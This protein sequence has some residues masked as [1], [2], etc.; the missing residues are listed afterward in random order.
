MGGMMEINHSCICNY[1]R[2]LL[3]KNGTSLQK[4]EDFGIAI[5]MII[6]SKKYF[7]ILYKKWLIL[8]F[9]SLKYAIK[10][11]TIHFCIRKC[12]ENINVSI[13]NLSY[14]RMQ[15]CSVIHIVH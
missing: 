2:Q 4:S 15:L 10:K 14:T 6:T 5:I 13:K 3:S 12:H 9:S 8:F 1:Y 11:F 7:F